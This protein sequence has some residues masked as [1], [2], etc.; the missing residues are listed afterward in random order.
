MKYQK[1]GKTDITVS[2]LCFGLLPM[3]PLQA[4]SIVI[5]HA[6]NLQ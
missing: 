3:E 4:K 5:R 6:P 1:L 2:E